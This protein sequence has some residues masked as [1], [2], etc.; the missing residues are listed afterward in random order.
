MKKNYWVRMKSRLRIFMKKVGVGYQD[1]MKNHG[2]QMKSR[3]E[4]HKKNY[5]GEMKSRLGICRKNV[6]FGYRDIIK[7][8]WVQTKSCFDFHE[9]K[10]W[11]WN[12]K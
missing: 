2:V 7:N 1:T 3:F 8:H 10:L 11:G 6:G 4:F 5:E 12:E 9:E